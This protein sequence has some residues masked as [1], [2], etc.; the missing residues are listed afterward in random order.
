M[1]LTDGGEPETYQE[2]ILHESKKGWVKVMQAEVRSLI[3]NH[4]YDLVKL[5]QGNKALINKLVYR[6]K[7][8]NNGSQLR[9]KAR[10]IVKGFNQKKGINFEEI[11]S[12]VVKMSSIR[13]VLGLADNL[14]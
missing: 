9:Y 6:L 10:L 1:M 13:V 4:I 2:A 7:T 11:F 8:V 3:E 14:N 5:P 12:P